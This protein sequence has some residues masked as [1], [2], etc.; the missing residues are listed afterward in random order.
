MGIKSYK[1]LEVWKNCIVILDL[2]YDMTAKFPKEETYG[3]A[4]NIKK[5]AISITSNIVEGHARQHTRE[6]QQFCHSALGS[7][8]EL[9]TQLTIA[10]RRN[11]LSN[12][13]FV[14]LEEDLDHGGP[15]LQNLVKGL[16]KD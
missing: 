1:D 10:Q 8:A 14:K 11:Y 13:D 12:D 15:V 7:C 9:S 6:Y 4:A 16:K 3:L 2:V 5:R